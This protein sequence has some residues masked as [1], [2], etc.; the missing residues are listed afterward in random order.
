[1]LLV[2]VF[3][4]SAASGASATRRSPLPACTTLGGH[5]LSHMVGVWLDVLAQY[6]CTQT[7]ASGRT[8]FMENFPKRLALLQSICHKRKGRAL[9]F[10]KRGTNP[11]ARKG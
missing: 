11:N 5:V 9:K 8:S 2:P 3:L 7:I 6:A 10:W 1:M 4:R